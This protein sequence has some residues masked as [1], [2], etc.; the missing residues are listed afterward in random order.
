MPPLPVA[1]TAASHPG[2]VRENNEDSFAFEPA[3]SPRP[4]ERGI[5]C[6][7]ADGVGGQAA[8]EVASSTAVRVVLDHY[9]ASQ[10]RD[11]AQA[12][13]SAVEDANAEVWRQAQG[14]AERTGM[15]STCT[16]ALVRQDT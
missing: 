1:V 9:Y 15:A 8:G 6:V 4:A 2:Q 5:L 10:D 7:V 14:R 12:L 13:R 16:A 3:G 11:A